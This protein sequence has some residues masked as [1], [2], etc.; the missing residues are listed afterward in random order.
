MIRII[1]PSS[2][3]DCGGHSG[4]ATNVNVAEPFVLVLTGLLRVDCRRHVNSDQI[5]WLNFIHAIFWNFQRSVESLEPLCRSCI[6]VRVTR[7]RNVLPGF[8]SFLGFF[9][10]EFQ[11]ESMIPLL[12]NSILSR[13]DGEIPFP[14]GNPEGFINRLSIVVSE[15]SH[16]L[17]P[18]SVTGVPSKFSSRRAFSSSSSVISMIFSCFSP[19]HFTSLAFSVS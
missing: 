4:S 7:I 17:F 3:P 12:R 18:Y 19:T 15:Q 13:S 16:D 6:L 2:G 5:I 9:V 8:E 11:N 10:C 1:P 14:I